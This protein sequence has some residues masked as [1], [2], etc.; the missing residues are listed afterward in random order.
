MYPWCEDDSEDL[1]SWITV[2]AR[3]LIPPNTIVDVKAGDLELAIYNIDG[4][5]YATD[6][7]C[8]HANARLS[9]GFLDGDIV[10]CPLHGGR[11]EVKTGKGLG[12]PVPCD[13]RVYEVR[14]SGDDIQVKQD[15]P[16]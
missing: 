10:E 8:T 9:E 13:L 3:S 2:A 15:S 1:N 14:V 5:F 12:A 4:T 7:F 16:Y 11:F 6:V